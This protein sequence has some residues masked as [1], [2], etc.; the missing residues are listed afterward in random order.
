MGKR[1]ISEVTSTIIVMSIITGLILA[2]IP[3]IYGLT[4]AQNN[5]VEYTYLRQVFLEIA[6]ALPLVT[7]GAEYTVLVPSNYATL[8][9]MNIGSIILFTNSSTTPDLMINCTALSSTGALSITGKNQVYGVEDA[10]VND[11]RL[12]PAVYEKRTNGSSYLLL[13]TCR[14]YLDIEVTE[15]KGGRMYYYRFIFYNLTVS[16]SGNES[17]MVKVRLLGSPVIIQ[18]G[19]LLYN[20]TI[21]VNDYTSGSTRIYGPL[22]LTSIILGTPLAGIPCKLDIY[23]SNVIMEVS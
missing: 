6:N 21:Q 18:R 12:I 9:Y 11:T 8:G 10:V 4:I 14:V 16:L 2:L 5:A 15:D 17:H 7:N 19:D 1:L 3:Y 20:L 23:I 22:N 13:D